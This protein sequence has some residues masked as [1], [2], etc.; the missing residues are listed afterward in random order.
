MVDRC[1]ERGDRAY[2]VHLR[3]F[4]YPDAE[5]SLDRVAEVTLHSNDCCS[6]PPKAASAKVLEIMRN[7]VTA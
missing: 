4:A 6:R 2:E 3:F 7:L 1:C 5:R